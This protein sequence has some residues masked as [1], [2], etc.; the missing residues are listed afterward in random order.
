MLVHVGHGSYVAV[1][2][3]ISIAQAKGAPMRRLRDR[4]KKKGMLIDLRRGRGLNS[5]LLL[6]T[7]HVVLSCLGT[8][9]LRGRA[10]AVKHGVPRPQSIE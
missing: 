8:G 1:N 9:T 6:D 2:R 3:I 10:E 7:G 5:L 4:A